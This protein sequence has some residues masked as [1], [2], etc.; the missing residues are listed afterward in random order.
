MAN[1]EYIE[2][3]EILSPPNALI[4]AHYICS[5]PRVK[6]YCFDFSKV[7]HCPPFGMLVIINAIDQLKRKYQTSNFEY[8]IPENS[9]SCNYMAHLGFF[10]IIGHDIGRRTTYED[11]TSKCIPITKISSKDLFDKYPEEY[12]VQQ[13]IERLARDFSSTLTREKFSE[14]TKTLSYCIRE[15]LRN[16]F[17]HSTCHEAYICGQYWPIRKKTELAIMDYGCGIRQSLARNPLYSFSSDAEA[18][19][20]ALQPGVS[21]VPLGPSNEDDVWHNSGYGLYM[22][23]ALCSLGGHFILASGNDATFINNAAQRN[24]ET[25]IHGTLTC[26]ALDIGKISKLDKT[27]LAISEKGEKYA[28]QYSN[29]ILTASKVSSIASLIG[30]FSEK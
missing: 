7:K 4:C 1:S 27:L 3:K 21:S 18:N 14:T 8:I 9:D 28:E 15:I 20:L 19:K 23:S 12:I 25:R 13:Q 30:E 10:Q 22:A 17:E 16:S 2:I 5:R 29:R 11:R 6:N 24:Y 26:L